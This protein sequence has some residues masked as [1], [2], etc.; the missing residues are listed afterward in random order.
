MKPKDLMLYS[1]RLTNELCRD[2]ILANK[3]HQNLTLKIHFEIVLPLTLR[4][5]FLKLCF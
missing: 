4:N 5:N 3:S 1:E 2:L